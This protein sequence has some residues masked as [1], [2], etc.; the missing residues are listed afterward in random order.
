MTPRRG[1]HQDVDIDLQIEELFRLGFGAAQ[2]HKELERN[3][4]FKGRVPAVRT[5][6]RR[7]A[8]FA[9]DSSGPWRISEASGQDAAVVLPFVA[10]LAGTPITN[11]EAAWI[12]RLRAIVPDME[13]AFVWTLVKRYRR[14]ELQNTDTT[15]YDLVLGFAPWQS[16]E[17]AAAFLSALDR[18]YPDPSASVRQRALSLADYII[19]SKDWPD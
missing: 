7:I 12:V 14:A 18:L 5:I 4:K 16:D 13:P 1:G 8:A 9:E 11:A 10:M 2:I 17:R 6:R 15:P 19:N 3:E